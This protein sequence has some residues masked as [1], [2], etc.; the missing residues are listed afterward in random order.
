M[1]RPGPGR[2]CR[3]V[4]RRWGRCRGARS[5]PTSRSTGCPRGPPAP[6]R[7]RP[8][9]RCRGAAHRVRPA[10][11]P[12]RPDA[13]HPA[14]RGAAAPVRT[15]ARG[16]VGSR[17]RGRSVVDR[18]PGLV[19]V[20]LVGQRLAADDGLPEP[21]ERLRLDGVEDQVLEVHGP[22]PST[23]STAAVTSA[24]TSADHGSARNFTPPDHPNGP[25]QAVS[26]DLEFSLVSARAR[27]QV[28]VKA[29]ARR[30]SE[31]EQ[32][33]RSR[34]DSLRPAA[35]AAA[36]IALSLAGIA[37]AQAD[38]AAQGGDQARPSA[39]RRGD[40]AKRDALRGPKPQGRPDFSAHAKDQGF[41]STGKAQLGTNVNGTLFF[42]PTSGGD[43]QRALEVRRHRRR[44]RPGQGHQPRRRQQLPRA[45]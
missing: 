33:R 28:Q 9:A 21:S 27:R 16:R 29:R 24:V 1:R 39:D 23:R 42:T 7:G 19:A 25:W 11:R 43:R 41:D 44:H 37:P 17:G 34:R 38:D 36:A 12:P 4:A 3:A 26:S 20:G 18:E 15:E 31:K 32:R 45:T 35:G 6:P 2:R 40:A 5:A 13:N 10:A 14:G 30:A 22:H 8:A